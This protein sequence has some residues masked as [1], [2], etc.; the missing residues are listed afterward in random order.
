MAATGITAFD[1]TLQKTHIFI[2]EVSAELGLDDKQTAFQ[3]L[4][5]TLQALRDRIPPEEAAQ[6]GAQLPI[7]LAG[8][9]YQGWRPGASPSK[10]RS[11]E[12]FLNKVRANLPGEDYPL[13]IE[14]LVR[15]VFKV[16][17]EQVS[18]GEIEE[19]ANIMPEDLRSLWPESVA[20]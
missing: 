7:L 20:A 17:S 6:L 12:E 11:L 15:G 18:K 13:E 10:E 3:G 14:R 4:R 2:N 19:I 8:F 1:Q 16:L 9:Y 5:G